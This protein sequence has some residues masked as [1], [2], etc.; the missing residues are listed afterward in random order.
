MMAKSIQA[1]KKKA[2]TQAIA[3]VTLV[4]I[5]ALSIVG[6]VLGFTGMKLD[7]EG[8]Y[9][10]LAWLPTPGQTSDWRQRHC[11]VL[12]ATPTRSH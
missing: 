6:T 10:L 4:V 7:K 9:K 3:A 12:R 8:L 5:L 11:L 2:S 1:P